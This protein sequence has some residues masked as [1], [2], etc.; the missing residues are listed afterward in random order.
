MVN[1]LP[2]DATEPPGTGRWVLPVVVR[3]DRGAPPTAPDALA[4]VGTAVARFCMVAA[5]LPVEDD[6][7][8]RF[9]T[10][11][12]VRIA[13]VVRRARAAE[14]RKALAM[15]GVRVEAPAEVLVGWPHEE[16][17]VPPAI[18]HAQIH[19]T[20]LAWPDALPAVPPGPVLVVVLLAAMTTGKA[21][22]QVGHAAQLAWER[23]GSCAWTDA[24]CPVVVLPADFPTRPLGDPLVE[25][26]DSGHTEVEPGTHTV[27]AWLVP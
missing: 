9:R 26:R 10:W 11:R 25:V 19:G 17:D 16:G 1:A 14:W 8:V 5:S 27:S 23:L 6:R 13:K 7:A 21:A 22:A 2:P 24:G 20:D 18:R 4:A 3:V 12:D 15:D